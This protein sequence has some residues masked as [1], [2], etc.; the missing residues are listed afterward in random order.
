MQVLIFY[1][2]KIYL[3]IMNTLEPTKS[4]LMIKVSQ[5]A[6][7][8]STKGYFGTFTKCMD[9]ASVCIFKCPR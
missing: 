5:S 8:L 9:Y 4:A 1:K 3:F 7:L 6:Y 2:W